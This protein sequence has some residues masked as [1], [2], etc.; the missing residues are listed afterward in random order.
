MSNSAF[1]ALV[2]AWTTTMIATTIFIM[3][4]AVSRVWDGAIFLQALQRAL[5]SDT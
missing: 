1:S 2:T 5:S 4:L 3:A